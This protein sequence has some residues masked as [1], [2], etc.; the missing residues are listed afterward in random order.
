ML[1]LKSGRERKI[2]IKK[3]QYVSLK[4][5]LK[6]NVYRLAFTKAEFFNQSNGT[7]RKT[8]HIRAIF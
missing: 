3:G 6:Y 1:D 4:I 2:K 5:N 8:R 7:V